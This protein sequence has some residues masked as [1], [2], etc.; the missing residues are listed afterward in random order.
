[1]TN[2]LRDRPADEVLR[3]RKA[4]SMIDVVLSNKSMATF[5]LGTHY[6]EITKTIQ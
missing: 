4:T 1:M 2:S 5:E 6:E 3:Q